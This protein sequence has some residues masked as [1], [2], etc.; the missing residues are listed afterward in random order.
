MVFLISNNEVLEL[1]VRSV[2]LGPNAYPVSEIDYIPGS[3]GNDF[4]ND[5]ARYLPG[6]E[7]RRDEYDSSGIRPKLS[8]SDKQFKDFIIRNEEDHGYPG[9]INLIGIGLANPGKHNKRR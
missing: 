7:K 4:L 1:L 6:I 8:G 5:V 3:N 9:F 2:K